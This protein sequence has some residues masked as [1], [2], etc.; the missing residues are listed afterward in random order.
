[1]ARKL[2]VLSDGSWIAPQFRS[3]NRRV[4]GNATLAFHAIAEH[5]DSGNEQVRYLHDLQAKPGLHRR[6]MQ[7]TFGLGMKAEIFNSYTFLSHN[8]RGEDDEIYLFGAGLGAC[9]IRRLTDLLDKVGILPPEK[10]NLLPEAY[11]YSQIPAEALDTPGAKALADH[12]PSQPARIRFLGCWDTV[13]SH[14]LPLP[15]LHRI[16]QS[17][18]TFHDHKVNANVESAYQALALDERR[19]RFKPGLWTGVHSPATKAVEQVWFP[20]SHENIVGGRRDSRLSDIALRWL[21]DRAAE[22]G[23][24][25]NMKKL[26]ELIMPDVMGRIAMNRRKVM[27]IRV[28][29]KQVFNR[30]VG[31]A[32]KGFPPEFEPEK[33]HESV[34]KRRE[35]D[36]KYRPRQL[37]SL[38]D[39]DIPV[40]REKMDATANK[41]RHP[42]TKI[43]WPGFIITNETKMNVSLVDFSQSG[44]KVWY[45]GKLPKGTQLVLQSSR[46]FSEGL[47]SRVVWAQDNFLGLEF[48]NPLPAEMTAS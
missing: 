15:G 40:F 16:S 6:L 17:W 19:S 29:F 24:H 23:L 46:A 30:P 9:N 32:G 39:S 48:T 11:E 20:G 36:K 28:P 4:P 37:A 18:M 26:E 42:R 44:A 12:L 22:Q 14:G 10:L 47:K 33:L 34:L 5:N 45:Q 31:F 2:V 38:S 41:R 43:D 1:M 27:G 35:L 3:K 25:V 8:Y 7:R 21:L 13:G